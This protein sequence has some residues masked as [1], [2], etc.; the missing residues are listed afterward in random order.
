VKVKVIG[1]NF[2]NKIKEIQNIQSKQL[3]VDTAF[4]FG[5][6]LQSGGQPSPESTA[7]LQKKFGR[8]IKFD[9]GEAETANEST[10][11]LIMFR[12]V[13]DGLEKNHGDLIQLKG[14]N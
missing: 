12:V 8:Y 11:K 3:K 14:G 2:S 7:A 13:T 10:R 6:K 5:Q 4:T 1:R 9:V